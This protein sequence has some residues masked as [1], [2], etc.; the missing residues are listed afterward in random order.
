[1]ARCSHSAC[2]RWRPDLGV[3]LLRLGLRV[4]QAWFCSAGCVS[5]SASARLR[6]AGGQPAP[7]GPSQVPLGTVLLQQRGI[8]AAQLRE[9][10][11]GQIKSGLRLGDQLLQLGYASRDVVLRALSAQCGVP[12]LAAIDRATVRQAPGQLSADEV[13]ALGLV[14]FREVGERL[15]VAC[16]APLPRTA[17]AALGRLTGRVIEPYLVTDEDFLRLQEE[18]AGAA[19]VTAPATVVRDIAEGASRIAGA[20][21]AARDVSVREAHVDPYTWVRIAADGRV[22]TLLVP[23]MPPTLEEQDTWLAATTPH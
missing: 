1:M 4:D 10:L 6:H 16:R 15:S 14:P 18:Y 11:A 19:P 8:T 7:R 21:A 20:A 3:Q 12:Y 17:I 23:P 5:A 2:G 9:A 22:S 13:R